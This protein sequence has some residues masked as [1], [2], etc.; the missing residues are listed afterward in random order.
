M[1][2]RWKNIKAVLFILVYLYIFCNEWNFN[3]IMLQICYMEG[4]LK[5][6]VQEFVSFHCSI[7]NKKKL[8][9]SVVC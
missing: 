3:D 8:V 2:V 9:F 1:F 7:G 5:Q 6:F 4:L